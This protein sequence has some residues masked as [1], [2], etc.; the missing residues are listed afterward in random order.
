MEYRPLLERFA[1]RF[2]VPPLRER[3]VHEACYKLPALHLRICHRLDSLFPPSCRT[4]PVRFGGDA[5]CL[6]LCDAS[7]WEMTQWDQALQLAQR[8]DG[9]LIIDAA[10]R[11]FYA[12]SEASPVS[13]CWGS[14]IRQLPK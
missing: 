6:M 5:P 14:D 2:I 1:E 7:G 9:L 3:F 11:G 10:L 12:E 8:G 13:D 4:A